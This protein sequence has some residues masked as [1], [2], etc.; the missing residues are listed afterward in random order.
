MTRSH[1]RSIEVFK[2]TFKKF[3]EL[4]YS[5][6]DHWEY[7]KSFNGL[8]YYNENTNIG[9]KNYF[10]WYVHASI[11]VLNGQSYEMKNIFEYLKY[12]CFMR[13]GNLKKLY[14]KLYF[15]YHGVT[16]IWKWKKHN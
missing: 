16:C 6:I 2:L 5:N 14:G 7:C 11:I 10:L 13:K 9:L 12:A 8:F 15:H 4:I 3:K 1:S